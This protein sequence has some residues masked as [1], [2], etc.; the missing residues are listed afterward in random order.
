[1][2][3]PFKRYCSQDG[4]QL[5]NVGG[6]HWQ[7]PKCKREF[8]LSA[9]NLSKLKTVEKKETPGETNPEERKA[10]VDNYVAQILAQR[11]EILEGFIAKFG[12]QPEEAQQINYGNRWKVEKID[13]EEREKLRAE[14]IKSA[15][16][17]EM[18]DLIRALLNGL[19]L[20]DTDYQRLNSDVLILDEATKPALKKLRELFAL[21]E[22]SKIVTL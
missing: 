17:K 14:V 16:A 6:G 8:V 5:Q 19:K 22:P 15:T 18:V 1:M 21:D 20:A 3:D 10:V 9:P 4:K 13:P 2:S 11:A 7:C 12:C